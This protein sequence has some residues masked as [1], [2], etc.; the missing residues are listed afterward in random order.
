MGVL[1][2]RLIYCNTN[3]GKTPHTSCFTQAV[4][5]NARLGRIIQVIIQIRDDGFLH[6]LMVLPADFCEKAGLRGEVTVLGAMGKFRI[7]NP[8]RLAARKSADADMAAE[9]KL[10]NWVDL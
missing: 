3:S 2:G 8:E 10:S 1:A 9:Q 5:K 6:F 4:Q 7:W